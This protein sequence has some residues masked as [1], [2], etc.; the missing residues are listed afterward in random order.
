MGT[1]ARENLGFLLALVAER[2]TKSV[3]DSPSPHVTIGEWQF[4]QGE[5]AEAVCDQLFES[6]VTIGKFDPVDTVTIEKTER[7]NY[8]EAAAATLRSLWSLDP[9]VAKA[10]E[11]KKPMTARGRDDKEISINIPLRGP[12]KFGAFGS[13]WFKDEIYRQA[14]TDHPCMSLIAASSVVDESERGKLFVWRPPE[15]GTYDVALQNKIDEELDLLYVNLR[16][17]GLGLEIETT[18][19]ALAV[20]V[21]NWALEA[22]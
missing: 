14:N 19:R 15:N 17:R 2:F 1:K 8:K 9:N 3:I 7:Y 12:G 22:A 10:I 13:V 11:Q 20:S 5:S 4:A 16:Q 6:V 21:R 18:P